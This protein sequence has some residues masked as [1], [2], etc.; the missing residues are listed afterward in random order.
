[1]GTEQRTINNK[2]DIVLLRAESYAHAVYALT[3]FF[4]KDELFGLTSQL[5]RAALSVPLNVVEGYAR[6]S[7]KSEIQFLKIAYGSLKESQFILQFACDETYLTA[8]QIKPAVQLGEESARLIWAKA[9]SL[10]K[11]LT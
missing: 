1:M 4:P 6:Q 8:E 3:K 11:K 9:K 2:Q 10:E 7:T 5:K